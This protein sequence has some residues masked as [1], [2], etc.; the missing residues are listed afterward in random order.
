MALRTET[1]VMYF[2]K[3]SHR[4]TGAFI[5]SLFLEEKTEGIIAV[6]VGKEPKLEART[7]AVQQEMI[8]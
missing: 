8:F 6:P 7:G 5:P 1:W 3:M 4:C 2:K